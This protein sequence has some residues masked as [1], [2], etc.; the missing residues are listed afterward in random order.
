MMEDPGTVSCQT[1][2]CSSIGSFPNWGKVARSFSVE[3][4]EVE[5]IVA[6]IMRRR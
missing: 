4:R 3:E 5:D 6:M 1:M 2:S